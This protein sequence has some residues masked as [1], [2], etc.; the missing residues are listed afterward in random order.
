MT[1]II[2]VLGCGLIGLNWAEAFLKTGF[3][4]QCW[5]PNENVQSQ[6]DVLRDRFSGAQI[7]Y[8]SRVEDAVNGVE[9]VQESGPERL[10]VKRGLYQD[11]ENALGAETIVA[12]STS[13]IM[14]SDLQKGLSY[15]A[16][17]VIG[18]PFNPPHILP[19]VE[20]VGGNLTSEATVT[21]AYDFYTA[22]GKQPIKLHVE[23]MGHLANRIQAAVWRESID[24]VASGQASV[25]DVELA[26]TAA[27]GPRWALMGQ[28]ETF[29]LA[30]GQGGMANFLGDI[31]SAIEALWDDAQRPVMTD[32]LKAKIVAET[33]KLVGEREFADKIKRRDEFLKAVLAAK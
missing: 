10:E 1:K 33:Q 2:A 17:F 9:F 6:I 26:I 13:T 24:A 7:D 4:V 8:F 16:R 31:G 15:A 5:D 19:L 25:A 3:R 23:R 22:V 20:V 12:S 29:D 14:P 27:L 11:I 18:H 21:K 32:E 30:G 28:F